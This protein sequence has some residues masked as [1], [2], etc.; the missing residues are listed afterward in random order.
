MV[1]L[2]SVATGFC[3]LIMFVVVSPFIILRILT[4][5]ARRRF[6]DQTLYLGWHPVSLVKHSPVA[7][8][9]LFLAFAIGFGWKYR[10]LTR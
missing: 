6:P 1:Y 8:L 5:Q 9:L 4:Y 3:T 2:K 10:R 7:W